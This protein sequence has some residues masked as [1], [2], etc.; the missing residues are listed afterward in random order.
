MDTQGSFAD[1]PLAVALQTIDFGLDRD[2]G[3]VST[4]SSVIPTRHADSNDGSVGSRT[5]RVARPNPS[6]E[7]R[8]TAVP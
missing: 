5:W 1:M 6:D 2:V 4:N 8:G 3:M 7:V